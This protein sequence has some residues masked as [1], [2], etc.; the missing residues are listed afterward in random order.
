LESAIEADE[1]GPIPQ[2][3]SYPQLAAAEQLSAIVPSLP[4]GRQQVELVAQRDRIVDAARLRRRIL[5]P[6]QFDGAFG[7]VRVKTIALIAPRAMAS[8]ISGPSRPY[9][10]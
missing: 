1:D 9:H 2:H 10:A 6:M 7:L 8:A 3:R 4:L 5:R